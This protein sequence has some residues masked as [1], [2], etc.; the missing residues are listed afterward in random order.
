MNDS[1]KLYEEYL[2]IV[3]K[4]ELYAHDMSDGRGVQIKPINLEDMERRNI[5]AK[6]LMD[7]HSDILELNPS[8]WHEIRVHA[9]M[10]EA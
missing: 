8:E 6:E 9:E 5:L 2:G 3:K 7:K 4:T 1:K 10:D